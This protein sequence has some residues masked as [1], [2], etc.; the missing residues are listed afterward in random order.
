M[1]GASDL[2]GTGASPAPVRLDGPSLFVVPG[3]LSPEQCAAIRRWTAERAWERDAPISTF[4]GFVV[5]K[6]IRNNDR[7]IVDDEAWAGALWGRLKDV[8]PAVG[9]A[10]A[11]GINERFRF[12]R[13]GPGMYFKAHYDGYYQRPGTRE[14]S[15]YTLM[16][17]LSDVAEGGDTRFHE[18]GQIVRPAEGLACVFLHHQ[19][20][21][22]E[23]VQRGEKWV[24]RTDVMYDLDG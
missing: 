13:Y 12:Y 23:E 2:F 9:A 20:H 11:I 8:F 3:L 19:L 7:I 5:R 14:R 18:A 4:E 15:L 22:G 6:D 16:I 10:R 21:A 1:S 24:L 17:Y